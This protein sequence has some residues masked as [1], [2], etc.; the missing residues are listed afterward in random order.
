M[1]GQDLFATCSIGIAV[2]PNEG[3]DTETLL[4]HARVATSHVKQ[5]GPTPYQ[6]HSESFNAE[7]EKRLRLESALRGALC[8]D[9]ILSTISPR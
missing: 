6:F 7:A 3:E 9:E 4:E 1:D 5:A 2:F 8:C